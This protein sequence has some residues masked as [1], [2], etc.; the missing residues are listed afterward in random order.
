VELADKT[1]TLRSGTRLLQLS[2]VLNKV[3]SRSLL[4]PR[5]VLFALFAMMC[6]NDIA[7]RLM[8]DIHAQAA[9][10]DV[11]PLQGP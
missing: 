3:I 1:A 10:C 9:C 7:P 11:D 6:V 4:A 5:N 2:K 8:L